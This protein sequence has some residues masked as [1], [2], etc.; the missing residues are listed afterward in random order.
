[1]VYV[2]LEVSSEAG[3]RT[4]VRFL[5]DSGAVYSVLP[6]PCWQQLSLVPKRTLDFTLVDGTTIR[7]NVSECRFASQ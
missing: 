2:D 3:A 4:N 6:E 1:L 5:V 7:R